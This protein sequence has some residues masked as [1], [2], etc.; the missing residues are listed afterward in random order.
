MRIVDLSHPIRTGMQVYPGDPE[1]TLTTAATI[2]EDGYQVM[3][4]HAGSHTGTHLDAPLHSIPGGA[5]VDGIELTRLVGP[6]RL[7]HCPGLRPG[8]TVTWVS[9]ADQLEAIEGIAMVFFR[10][11]W[12]EYYGSERYLDHPVMAAEVADR[13]LAAGIGVVGV[14]TLNPD[15]TLDNGGHLPFHAAFLGAGGVLVE[16]LTNLAEVTWDRPLVSVLPLALEGADGAPVRAVAME[17]EGVVVDR[18]SGTAGRS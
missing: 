8:E 1:V 18:P 6:A 12:S 2:D 16:N 17:L 7:V 4:L 10:T 9:V 5:P 15:S 14:D 13:L 3:S 11:G